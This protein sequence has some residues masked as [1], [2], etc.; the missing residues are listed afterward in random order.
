MNTNPKRR[1]IVFACAVLLFSLMTG[2]AYSQQSG[3]GPAAQPAAVS[4]NHPVVVV[5]RLFA[6]ADNP[7]AVK[8]A[9]TITDSLELVLRLTGKLTIKRAD[10]LDPT[11]SFDR[12]LEYYRQVHAGGAV[13]GTVAPTAS[14]G[15][16]IAIELWNS[17]TSKA[18][19]TEV[20]RNINNLLD[21]FNLTDELSLDAASQV[22]G[23]T[24]VE[25]TLDIHNTATLKAYAVYADGQLLGRN[26]DSFRVLTGERTIIVARPGALGDVP[27]QTFHVRIAAGKTTTVTLSAVAPAK[28]TVAARPKSHAAAAA[29]PSASPPAETA[30]VG[31]SSVRIASTSLSSS[32]QSFNGTAVVSVRAPGR[33]FVDG[34]ASKSLAA[35]QTVILT[36]LAAGSHRL[37]VKYTDGHLDTREVTITRGEPKVDVTYTYSP[38]RPAASPATG[39]RGP[40]FS[41]G[42]GGGL[43]AAA[44]YISYTSVSGS[45]TESE[46]IVPIDASVFFDANYL[47]ASVGYRFSGSVTWA[48]SGTTATYQENLGYLS[49][50]AFAKFP[51]HLGPIVLFPLLGAEYDLNV[52]RGTPDYFE[53]GVVANP[54]S[55]DYNE[56]WLAGGVGGDLH[57]TPRFF[58]RTE[59]LFNYKLLNSDENA[60]VSALKSLGATNVTLSLTDFDVLLMLGYELGPATKTQTTKG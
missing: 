60:V 34:V 41:I 5:T 31:T 13:Y 47:Q 42:A 46:T 21:S 38:T 2:A 54:T 39:P 3:K 51:F 43:S 15:Y 16:T 28:P 44:W 18:P 48:G 26:R 52:V 37:I 11:K 36:G 19:R 14:G 23:V 20:R 57:I 35:G 33:L 24:L 53:Q 7:V 6:P 59:V 32:T 58:I 1:C 30:P 25:G 4:P 8:L 49:F 22:V 27:V 50:A 17:R 56:L 29:R 9:S 55:A 40:V 45:Y 10:Y 12:A